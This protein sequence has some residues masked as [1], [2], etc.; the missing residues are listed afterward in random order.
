MFGK[1]KKTKAAQKAAS[2]L[3][4]KHGV[5]GAKLDPYKRTKGDI[6]VLYDVEGATHEAVDPDAPAPAPT[7]APEAAPLAEVSVEEV[8]TPEQKTNLDVVNKKGSQEQHGRIGISEDDESI[9]YESFKSVQKLIAIL[10]LPFLYSLSLKPVG[11]YSATPFF[12]AFLI[13][14]LGEKRTKWILANTLLIYFL[15]ILLFMV[16]LNAPLPQGNVSP[17]YDFSAFMLTINTNL[18]QY[19]KF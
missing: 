10:L 15:I 9:S 13:M 1:G 7:P 14:L 12:I 3:L 18:H 5:K 17:F 4:A 2:L 8:L 6:Y 19:I 16:L 11:F